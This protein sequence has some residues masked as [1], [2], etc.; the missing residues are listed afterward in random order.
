MSGDKQIARLSYRSGH[1]SPSTRRTP[2]ITGAGALR[3][4]GFILA[5]SPQPPPFA[6][7]FSNLFYLIPQRTAVPAHW[8]RRVY[9]FSHFKITPPTPLIGVPST[10]VQQ[11]GRNQ[12]P[13]TP[14]YNVANLDAIG[15][16][17]ATPY[18]L[19]NR[20]KL[21]QQTCPPKQSNRGLFG[22]VDKPIFSLELDDEVETRR[23]Q[24][25]LMEAARRKSHFFKPS[26]G[27]PLGK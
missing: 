26:V 18:F 24:R 3:T 1:V 5:Q 4:K 21:V 7:L 10:P 14:G 22:E 2:K 9:L 25:A 13:A 20:T 16:S 19:S 17:P 23:Q 27:S 6:P 12:V 15:M 11:S 8:C